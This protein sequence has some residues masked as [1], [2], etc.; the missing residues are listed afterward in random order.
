M[1]SL[2]P[3]QKPLTE[4][5]ETSF[6][7]P[8]KY[9]LDAEIFEL[10]K[11]QIFYK[12]WQYVAHQSMLPNPGDYFTLKICDENIFVIRSAD[13]ELRAFYNICRHRA[14]ELLSGTG[15]VRKLIVCPY[16]AWSYDTAGS[17][18]VAR[19]GEHRPGFDKAEF[20][21]SEIRLEIFCGCIFVNL[22]NDC[23]SLQT[24]ASGLEADIRQ[25]LPYLDD[26]SLA[27]TDLLGETDMD[28][29]WKVVVDNYVECYHCRPAHKDFAS[30]IDMNSYKVEVH[31]YWSSQQGPDIRYQNSAYP[32]DP[33]VGMQQSAFWYLW[34]NTTFNVLPG[35]DELSVFAIRPIDQGSS[36][37]GGHSFAVG[38]EVY[39]PRADYVI[40]TLAPEDINLCES[41]QRGLNSKSYDQGTFMVDPGNIGES[42]YALHHFHRLVQQALSA[43]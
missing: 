8:S 33:A 1:S 19:M 43:D 39:Q 28:A 2:P 11:Q 22:D 20:G 40:D 4:T 36:T 37:F 7:L 41:V 24:L 16:H 38:G 12:T 21:L 27:G 17:L 5:A 10:E 3:L 25:H 42:E 6:T 9:Y 29:G 13:G 15:N 35:S 30:L 32:V 31:D 34:P 26:I 18:Q 23:Q 14:H